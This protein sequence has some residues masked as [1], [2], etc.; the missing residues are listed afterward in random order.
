MRTSAAPA[1]R[2]R[3]VGDRFANARRCTRAH[4]AQV[5]SILTSTAK[6][7][8]AGSDCSTTRCGAGVVNTDGAVRRRGDD[9]GGHPQLRRAVVAFAGG[10]RVGLGHQLRASGRHHLRDVVHVRRDG[11]GVVAVDDGESGP[12][13]NKYSGT[14]YRT[15]GPP[16][17]AK[18]FRPGAVVATPV[19]TGD[20]DVQR[21]EQRYV[22]VH[23][24]RHRRPSRSR[25]RCS[26]RCPRARS[27]RW[28]LSR[29]RPTTRTCGGRHPRASNRAG[30]STSRIRADTIFVTWFTYDVDG[31]RCGC[32]PRP[33]DGA[34]TYSAGRSTGRQ[35]RRSTRAVP[36]GQVVADA[37]GHGT[38]RFADGDTATFARMLR[39][40][41][42]AIQDDH[43]TS[44]SHARY[45]MPVTAKATAGDFDARI[46]PAPAPPA[47]ACK[48]TGAARLTSA[49]AD[50]DVRAGAQID[51]PCEW[52]DARGRRDGNARGSRARSRAPPLPR[53]HGATCPHRAAA[54]RCAVAL[55]CCAST[56]TRSARW[57]RSR[58]A[59]SRPKATAKCRR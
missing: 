30:A 5:R 25:G 13:A 45:A 15:H 17:N 41:R 42:F 8:P 43:A 27:A 10:V 9:G 59:R 1:S 23:G 11:Q 37:G 7:F 4:A 40:R 47:G 24:Q 18:P 57:S 21:R 39:Q 34:G 2:R 46:G 48:L 14:L 19:G 56:R 35:D 33:Q 3:C 36:T 28:R 32:R 22:R 6:P 49:R 51:E 29:P 50:A 12:A 53:R 55:T 52:R 58:T 31:R 16:F 44:V 26:A 20:V 38:V 54:R